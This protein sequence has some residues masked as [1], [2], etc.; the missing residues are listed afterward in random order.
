MIRATIT[1]HSTEHSRNNGMGKGNIK[2]VAYY[3]EHK[4]KDM[5]WR[6]R[7]GLNDVLKQTIREHYEYMYYANRVTVTLKKGVKNP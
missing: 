4:Y 5:N 6:E 1:I 7:L 2:T 3:Q